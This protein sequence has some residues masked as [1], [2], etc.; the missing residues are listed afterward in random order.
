MGFAIREKSKENERHERKLSV[1][2]IL[3]IKE[4]IFMSM[5]SI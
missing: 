5:N 4:L 1:N 3:T 2:N